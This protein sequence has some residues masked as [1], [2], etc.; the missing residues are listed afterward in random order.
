MG[1][2]S[3]GH[4]V[5][6]V[7]I[8]LFFI[9]FV[10]ANLLLINLSLEK[11]IKQVTV[12]LENVVE[13]KS[14]QI[15]DRIENI[16]D[17][18]KI[19]IA[20]FRQQKE[21]DKFSIPLF[22]KFKVEGIYDVEESTF[23]GKKLS[24]LPVDFKKASTAKYSLFGDYII[25]NLS[26]LFYIFV[27]KENVEKILNP[28]RTLLSEYEPVFIL[29]RKPKNYSAFVCRTK[30]IEN[31]NFFL[32]GCIEK[33]S[34]VSKKFAE[35]VRENGIVFLF[36]FVLA[37]ALY[38]TFFKN[39]LLFPVIK[40]KTDIEKMNKEGLEK[41]R[42]TLHQYGTDEFA[43]I[44]QVLEETRQKILKH[45]K[46][47]ALVLETTSKM[48]SM[49]ND[50]HKFSL[51]TINRL[52]ELLNAEGTV[53]CLY[54]KPEDSCAF[55]VHSE[56]YLIGTVF[57]QLEN[58]VFEKFSEIKRKNSFKQ[59]S[60]SPYNIILVKKEVNE[61]FSI[62]VTVFRKEGL[63]SDEDI[64]YLDM[65][66]SHLVY[67]INLLNLA[68][69]D[70][71]TKMYNRRAV[72]QYATKEVER[73]I[74]Y[75]HPFSV[76]LLDIDDFKAVNDTYGHTIGDIVLKKIAYLIAEEVRETD[77]VGRY[78]GEE[79][80]VILPETSVDNAV[81]LAER[82]RRKISEFSFEINN[83]V[84][85]ITVSIGVAGLGEHG[86]TFEEILQAADLALYEAKRKG[87]NRVAVLKKEEIEKIQREEFQSKN[88]LE[89]ALQENRVIPFFQPI[90]DIKTGETAG[91]EILARIKDKNS[92]IP[93]YQF[94]ST[95][96]KF[97]IVLKIDEIVQQK[98]IQFLSQ[99][100]RPPKMLFF[101]LSRPYI[102]DI[103]H[104]LKLVELL[105]RYK[106]PKDII[107][108][109]ITEEEAI[110]EITVVKEAIR[111]AKSKGIRFALDDFGVGYSTFSYIKHFDI[112]II[113]LD[114]SL[115]KNINEDK[116][117]QIIVGG[118]AYICRKK[119]IKLLA[120][121]VET[122]EELETLK[123]LGVDYAQGFLFG[124]ASPN[125]DKH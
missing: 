51:Y 4:K 56:K 10:L 52:D 94:I 47:T 79:F 59:I 50:I 70:P 35:A 31:S 43:Q 67:S 2:K 97:G 83:Y 74:R 27:K 84:L 60:I 114:G 119:G 85:T 88:F 7:L 108:L 6:L 19:L 91:Y 116:D 102:Q 44:S 26:N 30:K 14:S 95:S 113:K 57:S 65:V 112:D 20:S 24:L 37:V 87:K 3:Y 36:F 93:A 111:I 21:K 18:G 62:Y 23:I 63:F 75:N 49:T 39:I 29:D 115:V 61:E 125:M 55:K 77:K 17:N 15:L 106:I 96:I 42:F 104:I 58:F 76:I 121:M 1:L 117:N 103:H 107:V 124:K 8:T 109:E 122:E 86:K 22:H 33:N 66:L 54:S 101:N 100:D 81:K 11:E 48:I 118:I 120:E 82:I 34:I 71:L 99:L 92:I 45:Q 38:G 25:I 40:L 5:V 105:E 68:T 110:S 90:V 9:T 41:V 69:Y 123:Q 64:N 80:I 13:I 28:D 89:K 46:G 98:T 16:E 72:V 32:T 73:S 53:L 78:G 12:S